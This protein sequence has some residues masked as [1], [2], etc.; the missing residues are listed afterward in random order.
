MSSNVIAFISPSAAAE[1]NIS[2]SQTNIFDIPWAFNLFSSFLNTLIF[3]KKCFNGSWKLTGI[4]FCPN[5]L[6]TPSWRRS[7]SYRKQSTDLLCKSMDW[8]LCDRDLRHKE[9][10]STFDQ[11]SL[12]YFWKLH[13]LNY[14]CSIAP[15]FCKTMKLII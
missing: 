7:V 8:F 9:L 13:S 5:S 12:I 15:H 6:L 3:C 4:S 10:R 2:R 14:F 11:H 1:K